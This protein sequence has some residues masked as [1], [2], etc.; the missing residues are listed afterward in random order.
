MTRAQPNWQRCSGIRCAKKSWTPLPRPHAWRSATRRAQRRRRHESRDPLPVCGDP[1]DQKF[2]ELARAC[3]ADFLI[4]KDR[5]LLVL[6][7][8][9]IRRAPFGIV[10]PAQLTAMIA[11]AL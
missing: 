11:T 6:A 2:L 4:T 8:R 9:K 10:T 5:E 1:D 7:R 3:G